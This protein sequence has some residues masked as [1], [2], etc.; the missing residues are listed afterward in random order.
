MKKSKNLQLIY[1]LHDKTEYVKKFKT[2][3]NIK[4]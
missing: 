2:V 1:N 4:M 3:Y